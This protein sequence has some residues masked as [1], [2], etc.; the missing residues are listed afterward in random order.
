MNNFWEKLNKP[1][2]GMA[3]MA[4]ITDIVFRQMLVKFGKPDIIYTEFVSCDGLC[5]VG[6]EK[7]LLDFKFFDNERPIVA[8]VFGS[9]P[10]NFYKAAQIVAD[11]GFDGIDINMGCP[12]KKVIK[13]KAGSALIKDMDLAVEIIKATKEGAKGL[14]V[15]V[16]TRTGFYKEDILDWI[17]VLVAAK[18]VAIALHGRT[19][20]QMYRGQANWDLIK[21]TSQKI[22]QIDKKIIVLGNGDIKS[23]EEAYEYSK[24]YGVDGVLVG[25]NVVGKP[26]FF[27]KEYINKKI[28]LFDKLDIIL[29]HCQMYIDIIADEKKFYV[30]RKFFTAYLKG[31]IG[32]KGLKNELMQCNTFAEVRDLIN[33]FKREKS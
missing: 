32:V 12:D 17:D 21:E 11:L 1:I 10:E 7:L 20:R 14:P 3:P 19:T 8:Q 26:W 6:K 23:L 25:R 29:L 22:K 24:I 27:S 2:L 15:S 4:D 31:E 33:D 18:P 28:S 16:K 5:S 30:L 13:Q 9:K